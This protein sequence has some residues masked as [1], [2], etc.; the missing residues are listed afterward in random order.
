MRKAISHLA[1]N[2]PGQLRTR[3]IDVSVRVRAAE[4]YTNSANKVAACAMMEGVDNLKRCKGKALP[5]VV[6][7]FGRLGTELEK[8]VDILAMAAGHA[9]RSS[10]CCTC[11][12][13]RCAE[14]GGAGRGRRRRR[15][16]ER[17][18]S[19]RVTLTTSFLVRSLYLSPWFPSARTSPAERRPNTTKNHPSSTSPFPPP[20]P[21]PLLSWRRPLDQNVGVW[22]F[23]NSDVLKICFSFFVFFS[24]FQLFFLFLFFEKKKQWTKRHTRNYNCNYIYKLFFHAPEASKTFEF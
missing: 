17:G 5:M 23:Q 4:R 18:A 15:Q 6:E 9:A 21:P 19:V 20:P 10:R 2:F 22:G 1:V 8:E 16:G 13:T 3:W 7:T 14:R 12:E 11:G 24:F